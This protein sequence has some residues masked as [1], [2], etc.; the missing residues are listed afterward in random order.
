MP[1]QLVSGTIQGAIGVTGA[2]K[3]V[4]LADEGIQIVGHGAAQLAISHADW[5]AYGDMTRP[6]SI[7]QTE[8]RLHRLG[9]AACTCRLKA[10]EPR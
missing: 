1:D 2:G 5:L 10:L 7:R 3:A 9:D 8:R 6:E 4:L